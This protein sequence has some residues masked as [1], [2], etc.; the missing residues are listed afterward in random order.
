MDNDL[1][2]YML[3]RRQPKTKW[4]LM[5]NN[6]K[7]T[8]QELQESSKTWSSE[9]SHNKIIKFL[10]DGCL[11]KDHKVLDMG[12]RNLLTEKIERSFNCRIENTIHDLNY[13]CFYPEDWMDSFD[14]IIMS[15][16][17]EHLF[18]PLI[19]ID[20]LK[21]VLKRDGSLILA[22]PLSHENLKFKWTRTH[23]HEMDFY[24]LNELLKHAG[25]KMVHHITYPRWP[26]DYKR[27]LGIRMFLRYFLEKV[28]ICECAKL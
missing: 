22:T 7:M 20:K 4:D 21:E 3:E 8:K 6:F 5:R 18:N 24:R 27:F 13:G 12:E 28:I 19:C 14:Y 1:R 23:F 26:F 17:V 9:K 25:F 16:V 10:L 11:N 2:L 15:H